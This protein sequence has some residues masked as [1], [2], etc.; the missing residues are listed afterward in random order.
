MIV[1]GRAPE[2]RRQ[3]VERL[4]REDMGGEEQ[5]CPACGQPVECETYIE[6]GAEHEG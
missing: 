6:E 5:V 3:A 1:T 2:K 4:R